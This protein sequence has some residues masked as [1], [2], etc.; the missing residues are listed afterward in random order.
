[1]RVVFDGSGFSLACQVWQVA[2]LAAICAKK[3]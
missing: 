1:M 3:G 2:S